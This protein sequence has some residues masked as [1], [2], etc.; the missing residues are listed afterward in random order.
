MTDPPARSSGEPASDVLAAI[1]LG[2]N[3]FHMIIAR[4]IDD[5]LQIID[6]LKEM[7][8]LG[9]GLDH[10]D[11]LTVEAQQRALETLLMFGER[12][13]GMPS[14]SV[15]ALG[16]NTLRK[17]KNARDFLALA[18]QA[19]GHPIE[20]ISGR[21][22]GRIVY[23]GVAH[24][25][26]DSSSGSR[27][28]LDIGGG[29]TEAILG[30][31]FEIT[32]CESLYMGCVS[33]SQRYFEGG[34][35]SSK[36][37]KQA[38]LAT[39][40]ELRAI[41][42][43]YTA[44]GWDRA[45]G[46]SGTIKA[47]QQVILEEKLGALGITLESMRRLMALTIERGHVTKLDLHGLSE[48]RRPVFC[49]GLAILIGVFESLNVS[50]MQVS[51]YALREG[52][53]YDLYGRARQIDVRD[54][55]IANMARR[56]QID[57]HHAE[58]VWRS[59]ERL[60]AQVSEPWDLGGEDFAAQLRRACMLHEI[61]L[62]ISHSRYHKHGSYIVENSDMAGFSRKD[63]QLLWALV[64]THRR[65]FKPHRFDALPSKL[66]DRGL[67]LALVLRLA[68]L[69]NRARV[70]RAYPEELKLLVK[71][72]RRVRLIF[73]NGWLEEAPLMS[74][75]LRQEQIYLKEAG[76]LLEYR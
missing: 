60:L 6:R 50:V 30:E 68:V 59:A 74:E 11:N 45:F 1:D 56:Y 16:T 25:I 24:S 22:E 54:V 52:A 53:I 15:R 70:E 41:S 63:Q 67:R 13:K 32:A 57:L 47:I 36:R 33:Y 46:S 73:P 51:D 48:R 12:L 66:S 27:L 62:A 55:T 29:S 23:L 72:A 37:Y 39:R 58:R 49:G 64:R 42:H 61:G 69:L 8:R 38:I 34:A 71:G 35:I 43:G 10:D 3:S 40:Q 26:F 4:V 7:V 21:E 5:Q 76:F 44:L 31:G 75:D 2:S 20:I 28:V 18:E 14:E 9:G 65:Q 19:L 17:A